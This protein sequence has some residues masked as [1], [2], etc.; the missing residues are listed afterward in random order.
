[1]KKKYTSLIAVVAVL[2]AM[3][4]VYLLIPE[5]KE[6][7][8]TQAEIHQI[9]NIDP[10][11]IENIQYVDGDESVQVHKTVEKVEQPNEDKE[12]SSEEDKKDS[13]EDKK[14]E[15]SGDKKEDKTTEEIVTWICKD[16]NEEINQQLITSSIT[17]LST[18]VAD[19]LITENAEDLAQYGLDNP[20]KKII[21][22]MEDGS[23]I[24]LLIGNEILSE[25]NFYAKLSSDN[26]V[27]MLTG[28]KIE[29][30]FVKK[31]AVRNI[32]LPSSSLL[33]P[34]VNTIDIEVNDGSYISMRKESG[35]WYVYSPY[36]NEI[37]VDNGTIESF[38][39][40]IVNMKAT[41]VIEIKPERIGEY[42]LNEPASKIKISDLN[43]E[44]ELSFSEGIDGKIYLMINGA[45]KV[46]T[47]SEY[48]APD[49]PDSA[50][51]VIVKNPLYFNAE[52]TSEITI[53]QKEGSKDIW[54]LATTK[55][56]EGTGA[57]AKEV[58]TT[59]YKLN[60][61]EK[62]DKYFKVFAGLLEK[63]EV[64]SQLESVPE[65]SEEVVSVIIEG[66]SKVEAKFYDYDENDD[67]Y[68]LE[69]NG[70][71]LFL[72]E[73]KLVDDAIGSIR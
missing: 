14:E 70:N 67:F 66:E 43:N 31:S 65:T 46:Y 33:G 29:G 9:I 11:K 44:Y 24:E 12:D 3:I 45:N 35:K 2:A 59:T 51:N 56:T 55:T 34:Q 72:M 8:E 68:V 17:S 61:E 47:L 49:I 5:K 57:E 30:F 58:V 27:Y 36:E 73:K 7:T 4:G 26:N 54:D 19:R 25:G 23:T 32:V 42:K 39:S 21:I 41:D 40:S 52:E 13:A 62:D 28:T 69:L 1:M 64:K 20:T 38:I 16:L 37:L 10:A 18:L 53:N 63:L 71:K 15:S 22:T 48:N 50:F 60:G 6:E